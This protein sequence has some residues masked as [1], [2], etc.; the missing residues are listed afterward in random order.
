M[1]KPGGNLITTGSFSHKY[2]ITRLTTK[3][4]QNYLTLFNSCLAVNV[5][6]SVTMAFFRV[7]QILD[8][9]DPSPTQPKIAITGAV[10]SE[11]DSNI[12]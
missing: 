10:N 2:T 9:L 3:I 6:V 5:I 1:L 12:K 11:R 4:T 8:Q 7:L